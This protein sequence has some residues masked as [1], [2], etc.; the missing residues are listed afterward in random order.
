[1]A[2]IHKNLASEDKNIKGIALELL[3]LRIATDASLVPL[4]FRLR[5]AETGQAEVDLIAE[6]AHLHFSR[7]LFQC[8]NTKTVSL[9]D[10]AKEVGMAVLLRAHVIVLVTTG[11]FSHSVRTYRKELM[12][13]QHFQVVLIDKAMLARYKSGGIHALVEFLHKEAE[14]TMRVKRLQIERHV[15]AGD[16]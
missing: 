10:L 16:V 5:A 14:A 6:G 1:L 15:E 2:E 11:R 8:K 7:W 3:A 4:R 9:S 13:T 12:D